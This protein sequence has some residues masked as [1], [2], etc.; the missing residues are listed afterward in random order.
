MGRREGGK[1]GGREERE[2]EGAVEQREGGQEGEEV[3][4]REGERK[5]G[6]NGEM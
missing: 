2:G 6:R 1:K 4:G 5:G 3:E